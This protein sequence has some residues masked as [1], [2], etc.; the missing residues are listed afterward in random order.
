MCTKGAPAEPDAERDRRESKAEQADAAPGPVAPRSA[1][2]RRSSR[3]TKKHARHEDGV[4]AAAGLRIES[5]NN[6]LIGD[7]GDLDADIEDD[8]ADEKSWYRGPK[9]EHC[10]R[11][12][13]QRGSQPNDRMGATPVGYPPSQGRGKHADCTNNA[14]QAGGICAE[15]ELGR[16]EVKGENGPEGGEGCKKRRLHD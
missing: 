14:E 10:P 8:D 11:E 5:V 3:A 15:I 12:Q 9:A 1:G 6:V 2:E 7:Q 13:C 4:D 16:C